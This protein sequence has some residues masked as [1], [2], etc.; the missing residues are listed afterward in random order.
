M[1]SLG[2]PVCKM[3]KGCCGSN[4]F[5][6]VMSSLLPGNQESSVTLSLIPFVLQILVL[7]GS[8]M[9]HASVL[10]RQK[11]GIAEESPSTCFHSGD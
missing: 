5:S 10:T 4:E 2:F 7:A 6:C 8:L 3:E 9:S 1:L 11:P